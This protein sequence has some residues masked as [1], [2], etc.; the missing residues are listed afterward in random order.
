MPG[1]P[2]KTLLWLNVTFDPV[3]G[4]KELPT[5]YYKV[6]YGEGEPYDNV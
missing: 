4:E 1:E 6:Y 3:M 2:N 5:L